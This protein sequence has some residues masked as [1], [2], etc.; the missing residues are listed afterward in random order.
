M[1]ECDYI[2]WTSS[3]LVCHINYAGPLGNI[4]L[5]ITSLFGCNNY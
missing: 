4:T 2:N 5:A 1:Q 3:I